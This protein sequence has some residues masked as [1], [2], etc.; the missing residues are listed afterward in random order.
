MKKKLIAV[1]LAAGFAAP[2]AMADVTLYGFLQG[3]VESVK[4]TGG[5][6]TYDSRTKVSDQNSRL[7]FKGVEDLGNGT[8]AIWQIESSL[9]NFEN[10]GTDDK[11]R[12]ASLGTRNTFVGLDNAEVGTLRLGQFD[13][14]YK[15][16]TA[17]PA[18]NFMSDTTADTH[19][20]SSIAGRGE[21]RLTNS[22]H[23]TTPVWSGF[24][25]GVSYGVDENREADGTQKTKRDR[26][27]LGAAYT[28]GSWVTGVGY[29]R[30]ADTGAIGASTGK[31]VSGKNTSFW[32]LASSYKFD[33]GTTIAASYEKASY[34]I[35][36]GSDLKQAGYTLAVSQEIGATTVGL[37]YNKLG[38]LSNV[39]GDPNDY[40][41]KQ[42]VLGA[43]YSLSKATSLYGYYTQ[44][45][46]NAGAA[47]NF[48]NNPIYS[49]TTPTIKL[50]AGNKLTAIG[51]GLKIAF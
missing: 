43:R 19:G 8:K 41:A 22:I 18:D 16:F 28:L 1:A 7:G 26:W 10:G 13:S 38:K 51:A 29:D 5:K 33:F 2:A 37:S 9:R 31:V 36:G 20:S 39:A 24:Q 34:G 44:I 46:N 50:D 49:S 45:K 35:A 3:G 21:A 27:S 42:W 32:Q 6:V 15:V 17:K 25:A 12:T 48:G 11:G 30:Q 23:Y 40:A 4:A 14:A 47:V